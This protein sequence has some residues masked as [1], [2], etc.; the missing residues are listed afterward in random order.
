MKL[1]RKYIGLQSTKG[2]RP[3]TDGHKIN[4]FFQFELNHLTNRFC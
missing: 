2:Q 4:H 1:W 3:Y